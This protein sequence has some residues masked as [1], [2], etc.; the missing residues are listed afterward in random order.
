MR[1]EDPRTPAVLAELVA[2]PDDDTAR[3]AINELAHY[4]DGRAVT[5]LLARWKT[6][7]GTQKQYSTMTQDDLS[8]KFGDRF[9][10]DVA[11]FELSTALNAR[12]IAVTGRPCRVARGARR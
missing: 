4:P 8:A 5:A 6:L 10:E 3:E 12:A 9:P 11:G 1:T 2:D 7:D